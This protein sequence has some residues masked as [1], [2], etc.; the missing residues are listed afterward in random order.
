MYF[1]ASNMKKSA[2]EK[3]DR[4]QIETRQKIAG[5]QIENSWKLDRKQLEIRQRWIKIEQIM[6]EKG[7]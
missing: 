6:V 2:N 7:Y 4:K 5:N 1:S 3:I